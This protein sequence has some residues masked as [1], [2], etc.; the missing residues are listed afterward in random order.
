VGF[1]L[2]DLFGL[3]VLLGFAIGHLAG[4]L[5]ARGHLRRRARRDPLCVIALLGIV[6]SGFALSAIKITSAPA[7]ERMVRSMPA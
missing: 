1:W 2:R 6:V 3:L 5:V 7:F 4:G